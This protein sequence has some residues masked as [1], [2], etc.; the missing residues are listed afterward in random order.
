MPNIHPTAL[1]DRNAQLADGVTVGPYAVVGARVKIGT[2]TILGTRCVVEGDTTIGNHNRIFPGALLGLEPQ[3]LKYRGE[4]SRLWIGDHNDIRENVTIHIGTDNG[5]GETRIGSHNLLMVGVHIAHDCRMGDHC[6]LAN[7]VMLAGHV[8]VGDHAVISGGAG[9]SHY[10]TIGRH[11]FIGGLSAVVR[12]CP[13]FTTCEGRPAR[14]RA[15]NLIGLTRHRFQDQTVE[16]LKSAH[17]S[18]HGRKS[19]SSLS[20]PAKLEAVEATLGGDPAVME[21]VEFLRAST[22]SPNGRHAEVARPDDKRASAKN[23]V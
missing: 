21:L 3:D 18:I 6:I 8:L 7:N 20:L 13:P 10:V 14:V 16:N 5:G 9:I 11:S 22:R 17:L 12:D 4:G 2:G 19:R 15:I 23:R 1:V